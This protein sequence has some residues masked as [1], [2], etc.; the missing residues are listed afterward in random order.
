MAGINETKEVLIGANEVALL[1][2]KLLRD[3]VQFS[4]FEQVYMNLMQN[5]EFRA[6]VLTAY[7]G[8]SAVPAEVKDLDL[9]EGVELVLIQAQYVPKLVAAA[10]GL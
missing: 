3:G 1:M 10:A 9:G 4:D 7:E 8:V 6:K 5:S 2:I